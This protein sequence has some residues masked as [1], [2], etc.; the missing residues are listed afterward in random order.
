MI[1]R[2]W[3][4]RAPGVMKG[5]QMRLVICVLIALGLAPRAYAQGVDVLRGS[6]PVGPAT[7]TNW[8]GFYVGGQWGYN[9]VNA[10]FSNSTQDSIAYVLRNSTLEE[11]SDPSSLPTLGT[12]DHSA[13]NYGGFVGYNSQWQDAI[14]GVEANFT[15]TSLYLNAPN[16]PIARSGFGDGNGNTYT[17]GI[18]SS[19]TITDLNYLSVRGRGG[20]ILGNFLPYGFV[21]AVLGMANINVSSLVQGYCETGSTVTCENFTFTATAG[22][23][24][25]L[26][27]GATIGGGI[28][29]AITQHL[30]LRGEFEYIRF[31]PID[32]VLASIIGAHFGMGFKF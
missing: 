15:H 14:L 9:D 2:D 30:F 21:G 20:V 13:P 3:P 28:D 19:G 17:I 32:H 6:E 23:E 26:L 24:S 4:M 16:D 18:T 7:F 11:N 8:S 27:Y 1:A 22:R 25:A 29:Y 10:D 5:R 31:A 12:A